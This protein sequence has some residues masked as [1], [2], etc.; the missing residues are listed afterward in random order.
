MDFPDPE[1]E[2]EMMY[3]DELEAM[4][5]MEGG[6][7]TAVR[8]CSKG[9]AATVTELCVVPVDTGARRSLDFTSPRAPL[10]A[11]A[12]DRPLEVRYGRA[13]GVLQSRSLLTLLTEATHRQHHIS[14]P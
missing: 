4:K 2:F 6:Y 8:P 1:E 11:S 5:E 13:G 12:A 9:S 10:S 3:A 14:A 7:S